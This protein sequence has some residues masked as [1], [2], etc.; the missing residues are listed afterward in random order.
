MTPSRLARNIVRSLDLQEVRRVLEPSCGDGSFVEA[1]LDLYQAAHKDS[2]GQQTPC[3]QL[4]LVGVEVDPDLLAQCKQRVTSRDTPSNCEISCTLL[5]GD[6][7]QLFMDR[8]RLTSSQSPPNPLGKKFDLIIGNPPFGGSFDPKIEDEVDA[9]LGT[10]LGRKI[11]KETYAFFI[12]ACTELLRPGGRLIFICSD[13]LLTIPTMTGLRQYLMESGAV[14]LHQLEEFSDETNYPML[15]LEYTHREVGRG[16]QR[17]GQKLSESD[18]EATPNLSWGV[19]PEAARLFRG[20]KLGDFFVASSGMTTGKNE[21]FVREVSAEN[22]ISEPFCFR[23]YQAAISVEYELE[24]ARLNKLPAKKLRMLAEAE[25]RGET[26]RR[27]AIEHRDAPVTISL[28]N[29]DYR[30]YNKASGRIVYSAPTHVI[31]WKDGGDAVLTYKRRGNWYLRGVGGQP[32]FGR[33]GLTWELVASRFIPRY[34]PRGYILDSGAPCAFA[35][36][37]V[38]RSEVLFALGWLLTPLANHVLKTVIN[39]TRNIQS[40]DFERM[41]YPWWVPSSTKARATQHVAEMIREGENGRRWARDDAD[42]KALARMYDLAE[43]SSSTLRHEI[44]LRP[45]PQDNHQPSLP[46]FPAP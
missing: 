3:D 22:T 25:A 44:R 8:C 32:F 11:K 9:I 12:V 6:F 23:F 18:V 1:F 7:F 31:Y 17:F 33:E 16:V 36:D 43:G 42:V 39:H 4:A 13:S 10:R 5:H 15:V 2:L 34:L 45:E 30:P 41:P 37:G 26:E 35:L 19:T 28:P 40:K 20:P 24:R 38:D 21:Y 27:L 46:L 29:D 14:K